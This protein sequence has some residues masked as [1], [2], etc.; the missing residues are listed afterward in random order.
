[1]F[2]YVIDYNQ[3]IVN[4]NNLPEYLTVYVAEVFS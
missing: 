3:L 2:R 4:I 1:M